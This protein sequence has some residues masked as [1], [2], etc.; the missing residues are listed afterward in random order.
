VFDL[1]TDNNSKA[2]LNQEFNIII[3]PVDN[4]APSVGE[5]VRVNVE[6]DRSTLINDDLLQVVDVDTPKEN[7][8]FTLIS[9]P[10]HGD[11]VKMSDMF[12]AVIRAGI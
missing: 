3:L 6:R 2:I 7:L 5:G 12:H 10:Q 11:I 9:L 4:K 8:Q 1:V